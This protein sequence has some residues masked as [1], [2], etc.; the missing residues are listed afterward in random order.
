[1]SGRCE[2]IDRKR[3][4]RAVGV[5]KRGMGMAARMSRRRA[6][7]LGA[8]ALLA[9][10]VVVRPAR[11]QGRAVYVNSYGGV[12]ESSWR[13]AFFEPFTAQT[14]IEIK[15]VPGVSFAKLK[16]QVRTRNFEWDVIN[17]GDVEYGQAVLEGLLE[18]VD[19]EAAK[20]DQLPPHMVRDYGITSYSLGTNLVYRKDKF[21]NGGPQSW[22]DFWDVKKFPGAVV[23]TTVHS[24][25][26][27]SRCWPMACRPTSSTPWMSTAPS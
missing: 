1:M 17:L 21:P 14:G 6:L 20:A 19:R 8:G 10:P 3:L 7:A 26:S 16:A 4:C 18:K 9:A 22:A 12:W 25:A 27:R 5:A 11:A 15:T 24:A 13:K 2:A 23:S